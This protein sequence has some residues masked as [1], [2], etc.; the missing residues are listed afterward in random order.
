MN[1]L[2]TVL[3]G[4]AGSLLFKL[5]KV[6][7]GGMIGAII[8]V[9]AFNIMTGGATFPSQVKIGVQAIAGGFIGQRI[10][11][12]DIQE[13]RTI[14]KP[15]VEL[16]LGIVVL[17]LTTGMVIHAISDVDITTAL[18]SSIPGGMSDIA[19]ISEDVGADPTQST[20]LQLVRYMIALLILP[21]V[22]TY[23]CNRFDQHESSGRAAVNQKPKE[24]CTWKNMWKTLALLAVTGAIGKLSGFPA[25]ALV[26]AMFAV[27]GYNIRTGKAYINK[28]IRLAAQCCAGIIVGARIGMSDI[29]RFPD[30]VLPALMVAINCLMIN[31]A[32]GLLIYKTNPMDLSTAMFASVPSGLSDMALISTELGGD[33]PKVAVLQL[34]RYLCVLAFMPS[35]IR[36]F[37]AVYPF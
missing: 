34:V 9:A 23:I 21:Q 14:I 33:A 5:L 36:M 20:V 10:T 24:V 27:A 30:L 19:M 17:S 7:A 15:S 28:W 11:K 26:F 1:L 6:P 22:D 37:S 18:I 2:L 29:M 31:Y 35:L 3:I 16:F 8:F 25:G 32:L 4:M 12:R 13:L